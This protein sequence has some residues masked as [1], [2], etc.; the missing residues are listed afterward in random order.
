MHVC[1]VFGICE[2]KRCIL[3]VWGLG[4]DSL[5][6]SSSNSVCRCK[7]NWR[8]VSHSFALF[9]GRLYFTHK[10]CMISPSIPWEG[11]L[12]P[13]FERRLPISFLTFQ[14]NSLSFAWKKKTA[15]VRALNTAHVFFL[16]TTHVFCL[17]TTHVKRPKTIGLATNRVPVAR[18]GLKLGQNES[19][20]L[21]DFF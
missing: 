12:N 20:G 14:S 15:H 6:A 10:R 21:Q 9:W 4:L 1:F 13:T 3:H 18:F 8:T 11:S 17:N 7:V 2:P 19:Q 5:T 16:N